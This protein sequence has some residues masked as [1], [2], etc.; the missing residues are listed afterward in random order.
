MKI[1]VDKFSHCAKYIHPAETGNKFPGLKYE[2][3]DTLDKCFNI[4]TRK[5]CI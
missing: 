3:F 2:K 1:N 4:P 5:R